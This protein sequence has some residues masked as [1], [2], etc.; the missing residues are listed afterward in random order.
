MFPQVLVE[1]WKDISPETDLMVKTVDDYSYIIMVI[2]M[3]ALA[4]GIINTMLMAIV[5]R[6][7]EMGMMTA[8]GTSK[9]RI[10]L[11]VLTETVLLTLAGTPVGTAGGWLLTRYF[12]QRGLDLSGMGKEMM[13][14]FGFR[15]MIYPEFPTE[16]IV[17]ILL[18]VVGTA[19]L[20][21]LLP[22]IK[23]LRLKPIDAMRM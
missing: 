13:A 3:L 4:F 8:L 1:T 23:A 17:Y 22:A 2:I 10:F 19:L 14:S 5:E 15:T 20:A 6:T 9:Q 16:K 12:H 18:I 21:A 7:R 11:L